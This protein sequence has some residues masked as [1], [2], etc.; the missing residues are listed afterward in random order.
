[1]TGQLSLDG[2]PTR[3][4]RVT[5]SRLATWEDCRRRFRL[6]AVDQPPPPRG[7]AWAHATLGAVVHNALRALFAGPARERTP[8]RAAELVTRHWSDEGFRDA[9]QSAEYRD[10]ARGWVAD[11]VGGDEA[12]A[13][14]LGLERWV[15]GAAG[16]IVAEGR[17]D[18]IDA[19]RGPHG[20]EAV[21]VDYKTGR[22]V[23]DDG[24]AAASPAL[25]LYALATA[26]TLRRRCRRVELHHLPS[27]TVAVAEHDDAS[28]RAHRERAEDTA[29]AIADALD[30]DAA[31][32][33]AD[34]GRPGG[35]G[36]LDVVFPASPGPRCAWCEVRRHCPEGRS[37]A[38]ALAS[39]ELLAP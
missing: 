10:R 37:A 38:P 1:M 9:A 16:G 20:D 5:P 24:D 7:G 4:L 32:V 22:R 28:L 21:V 25:A 11:Y 18:R 13:E 36:A 14:P 23:P 2:M 33:A 26:R 29:A 17:V 19:R 35:P 30:T 31:R 6:T 39:W 15:R 34:P 3:L 8:G 27:G 12:A